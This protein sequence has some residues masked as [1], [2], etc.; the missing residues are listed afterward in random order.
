MGR[1]EQL[2]RSYGKHIAVPWQ[3]GTAPAQRVIMCIYDERYEPVLR[4]KI[5]EFNLATTRT[6]HDWEQFDLSDSFARWLA[7]QR[8]AESYFKNPHLLGELAHKFVDYLAERFSAFIEERSPTSNTVISLTGVGSLFPLIKANE[9]VERFAPLVPGRL[10][11]LFPGTMVGN[12]YRLL[13]A[14]D[15]WDYLATSITADAIY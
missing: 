8:Y 12:N 15:G 5:D 11:V 9:L 4:A 10:L 7:E 14:Y 6:G 13:D 2:V 1:I 3:Q